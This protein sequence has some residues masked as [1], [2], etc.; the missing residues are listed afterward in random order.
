[1]QKTAIK[2]KF[3]V[4]H[5]KKETK[6]I[7]TIFLS[8]QGKNLAYQAGQY[9]A[10]YLDKN[11]NIPGKF[12]TISSSTSEKHLTL[13][14][15]KI[16]QFSSSLHNLKAKDPV[17][18]S[19]PYGWFYPEKEMNNVVFLAA[20]IGVTPF[21]S[22]MKDYA[23]R[24]IKKEIDLYYTNKTFQDIAFY[25]DLNKLTRDNPWRI[26]YYLTQDTTKHKLVSKYQRINIKDINDDLAS[27]KNKNYYICGPISF[28]SDMRKQLKKF[29]VKEARIFTESFY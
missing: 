25:E 29:K 9:V 15:K 16:G 13:S 24:N 22:I 7:I 2:S 11:D 27:L 6:D 5:I 26:R 28:V 23:N 20:G 10:V 19:G 14:I 1:M 17:Y 12:Y 18:L 8:P 4:S 21:L 3:L